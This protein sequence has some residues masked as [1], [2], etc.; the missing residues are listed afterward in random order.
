M[1]D[2]NVGTRTLDLYRVNFEVSNLKP[3]PHL[4]FPR[5]AIAE[6]RS[7]QLGFHGELMASFLNSFPTQHVRFPQLL[8]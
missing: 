4:A 3:F 7:K 6:N 2:R 5:F 1:N 8:V